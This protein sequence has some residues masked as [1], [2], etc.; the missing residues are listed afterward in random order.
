MS[1]GTHGVVV[2]DLLFNFASVG[3][4]RAP[5]VRCVMLDARAELSLAAGVKTA[6]MRRAAANENSATRSRYR[7]ETAFRSGV[8]TQ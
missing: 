3:I 8:R 6:T 7:S 2:F 4:A 1:I 5:R